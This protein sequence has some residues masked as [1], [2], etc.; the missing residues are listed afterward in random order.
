[1]R[2]EHTTDA[3]RVCEAAVF[4]LEDEASARG[5]ALSFACDGPLPA[6][7]MMDEAGLRDAVREL[8]SGAIAAAEGS[9]TVTIAYARGALHLEADRGGRCSRLHLVGAVAE[10]APDPAPSLEGLR[11]LVVDDCSVN[12]AL[13]RTLLTRLGVVVS[14]AEDGPTAL[15]RAA[16]QPFDAI[17]MDIR[18]PGLSGHQALTALRKSRGPNAEAPVLAFTANVGPEERAVRRLDRFDGIV[19][20]PVAPLQLQLALAATA[21]RPQ[22]AVQQ[23]AAYG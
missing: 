7:L 10:T 12:R 4:S 2:H 20:K 22:D 16:V 15:E 21:G 5:V 14:E 9:V 8:T 17:L 23:Q 6:A 11:V 3:L 19:R 18:M 1:M 13:A